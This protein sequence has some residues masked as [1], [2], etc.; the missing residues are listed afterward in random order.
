MRL[1]AI[2]HALGGARLVGEDIEVRGVAAP[3]HAGPDEIAPILGSGSGSGSGAANPRTSAGALLVAE[4]SFRATPGA[5]PGERPEIVVPDVRGALRPLLELF[6]PTVVR[7]AGVDPR[8]AVDASACVDA[9]AHVGPFAVVGAGA[10][11]GVGA[12]VESHAVVGAGA[13]VES[14]ARL[15]PHCIVLDGCRVGED[16]VVGPGAVVG[17]DGFGYD[18]GVDGVPRRIPSLGRVEIGARAEIGANATVDRATLGVTRVGHD[19]K[20]DDQVHVGHGCDVGESA[21]LC[22]QTGLAGSVRVGEGAMLGGQVG[23]ADHLSIGA[24]ARVAAKSGVTRDV[25]AG[26]TVAGYP[27]MPRVR[28]LRAIAALRRGA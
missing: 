22:G 27:A 23:V 3:E 18:V 1:A 2:C 13:I 12:I 6:A 11:I 15:F 8:A 24:R 4:K 28:W 14:G 19:A 7:P 20:L 26:D 21:L 10:T 16:A 5:L 9:S 25:A 17:F